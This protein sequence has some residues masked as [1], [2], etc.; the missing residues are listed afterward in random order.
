[1]TTPLRLF[2][3]QLDNAQPSLSTASP[4]AEISHRH[5]GAIFC[6]HR[7]N[8]STAW[9]NTSYSLVSSCVNHKLSRVLVG[10][11]FTRARQTSPKR[12]DGLPLKYAVLGQSRKENIFSIMAQAFA[13]H[14]IF[15]FR[16]QNRSGCLACGAG[17]F[18]FLEV[19]LR[20]PG[21]SSCT[22]VEADVNPASTPTVISASAYEF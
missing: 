22:S 4:R 13:T 18:V 14:I 16:A 6:L 20:S 19:F 10:Q 11:T 21:K 9:A 1:M 15:L 7:Q 17:V 8:W 3:S 2:W 12:S 5:E